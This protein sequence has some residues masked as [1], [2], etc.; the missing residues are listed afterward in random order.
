MDG[1]TYLLIPSS[2]KMGM[3]MAPPHESQTDASIRASL[4]DF[5]ILSFSLWGDHGDLCVECL[6][7]YFHGTGDCSCWLIFT[8]WDSSVISTFKGWISEQDCSI[9]NYIKNVTLTLGL[10]FFLKIASA[11]RI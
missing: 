5:E 10:H 2:L 11:I 7:A 3:I 4:S 1:D 9:N 6:L 8:E